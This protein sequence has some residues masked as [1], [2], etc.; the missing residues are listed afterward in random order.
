MTLPASGNPPSFSQ[1]NVELGY[2]ST[3]QISMNCTAFRTLFRVS[4][5]AIGMSSGFGKR[6][7]ALEDK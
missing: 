7:E 5:G 3:A 4:S 6:V 2:S 1:V